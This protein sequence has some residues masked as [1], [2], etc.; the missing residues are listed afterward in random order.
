MQSQLHSEQIWRNFFH[1]NAHLDSIS[2]IN[3][4]NFTQRLII[5]YQKDQFINGSIIYWFRSDYAQTDVQFS[6]DSSQT[7][8]DKSHTFPN[9]WNWHDNLKVSISTPFSQ[10][11]LICSTNKHSCKMLHF[12]HFVQT[13]DLACS[14]LNKFTPVKKRTNKLSWQQPTRVL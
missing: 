10:A 14:S 5:T 12:I 7:K 11:S 6:P 13:S 2:A 1:M 3:Y 8:H 4:S 9:N